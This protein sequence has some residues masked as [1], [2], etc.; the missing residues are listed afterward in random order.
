MEQKQTSSFYEALFRV[1]SSDGT[2]EGTAFAVADGIIITCSHVLK[3][4]NLDA[5]GRCVVV[6]HQ[7]GKAFTAIVL[8]RHSRRASEE[9]IST[10][11]IRKSNTYKHLQ[12][13]TFSMKAAD[14]VHSFGFPGQKNVEGMP[15]RAIV[16]GPATEAGHPVWTVESGQLTLGFSGAPVIDAISDLTV[17]MVM[18]VT[19]TDEVGRLSGTAFLIPAATILSVCPFATTRVHPHL[20]SY[21][22][23]IRNKLDRSP[24]FLPGLPSFSLRESF[25][26]PEILRV[27]KEAG[28]TAHETISFSHLTTAV[29]SPK[30]SVCII[31]DAGCGK[32]TMLRYFA[33]SLAGLA[34]TGMD[35]IPIY[36]KA[37]HL[38]AAKGLSLSDKLRTGLLGDSDYALDMGVSDDFFSIWPSRLGIRFVLFVDACDELHDLRERLIFLRYLQEQL[39][40]YLR[41]RGH[42]LIISSRDVGQ[43]KDIKR[44]FDVFCIGSLVGDASRHISRAIVGLAAEYFP[45]FIERLTNRHLVQ[46]PLSLLLLLTIYLNFNDRRTYRDWD[47]K[48]IYECYFGLASDEL[49]QRG[50]AKAVAPDVACFALEFLQIIAWRD[51]S[52]EFDEDSIIND[53]AEYLGVQT[54]RGRYAAEKEAIRLYR[55]L[56]E[57]AGIFSISSNQPNWTHQNFR[58][59]LAARSIVAKMEN[60]PSTNI[61][62]LIQDSWNDAGQET[63][64]RLLLCMTSKNL[65]VLDLISRLMESNR[66]FIPFLSRASADGANFTSNFDSALACTLFDRASA[67]FGTCANLFEPSLEDPVAALKLVVWK[68]PFLS[69]AIRVLSGKLTFKNIV[70]PDEFKMEIAKVLNRTI[71]GDQLQ[72]I[73]DGPDVSPEIRTTLLSSSA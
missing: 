65:D 25:Q 45:T 28:T 48:S 17:G 1:V 58:D 68:E 30:A 51:I 6:H 73:I 35:A 43:L 62:A 47:V 15:G 31:G 55:Y 18:S 20:D 71:G 14:S 8:K 5:K 44:T 23:S 16:T 32:S 2:T 57:D 69:L 61:C 54:K 60:D 63:F 40:P 12:F 49:C 56:A 41:E 4:G 37:K 21:C 50:I 11:R 9:D 64:A 52:G 67:A 39:T 24:Y 66:A 13:G 19:E 42:S 70:R 72:T 26:A 7:T 36:L 34:S 46:S 59:Y 53:F 38:A 22:E 10:L 27:R 33:M 3:S 29:F